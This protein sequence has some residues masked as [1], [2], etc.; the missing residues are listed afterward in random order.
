MGDREAVKAAILNMPNNNLLIELPTGHGKTA[1]AL[2]LLRARLAPNSKVLVVVPRIVLKRNFMQEVKRWWPECQIQYTLTTYR[3]LDKHAGNWDAVVYDEAHHFTPRCQ[4]AAK[5]INSKN[6]I[7]LSA[8]VSQR[9]KESLSKLFSNL[10]LYKRTVK[11]AIDN[12]VL[13]DPKVYLLPLEL[14]NTLE[15][16][17]I[18]KNPKCLQEVHV[19]WKNRWQYLGRKDIRICIHCTKKQ[20]MLDLDGQ[21]NW[22]KEKFQRT[23]QESFKNQWLK[24]C[25]NR[26]KILSNWRT[27]NSTEILKYLKNYRTLT[28]CNSIEHTEVLGKYCVNS[29]NK[30]YLNILDDFNSGRIKHI[31]ACNM[32]NEGVNLVNCRIGIYAV[33]NSSETLIKQKLGRL[34]RHEHPIL[35]VPYYVGTR[36]EEIVKTMLQD[37]NPDLVSVVKDVKDIV[38]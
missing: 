1:V 9:L 17:T 15:L 3:S 30:M 31:T 19:S 16:E 11:E 12:G 29:K 20:F 24:L 7:L 22:W 26:L 32:L 13:P 37:Y 4:E 28:F 34:L 5:K 27:S 18:I 23:R 14:D 10:G 33:L 35:I 38:L 25:G 21:I 2:E 36:E 6:S 8:T